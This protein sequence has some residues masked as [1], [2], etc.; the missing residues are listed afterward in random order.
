[1]SAKCQ[2]DISQYHRHVRLELSDGR[3]EERGR[4][5]EAECLGGLEVDHK[6]VLVRRLHRKVGRFLALEDAVD[7]AG[8]APVLVD[9]VSPIGDQPAAGDVEAARVD[10]G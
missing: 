6:L 5:D 3:R 2:S 4:H 1:M 7:I 10:R 8:R 9:K